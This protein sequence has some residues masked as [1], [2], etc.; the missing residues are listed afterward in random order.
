MRLSVSIA[1]LL[2]ASVSFPTIAT[3]QAQ[4]PIPQAVEQSTETPPPPPLGSQT[5]DALLALH[6]SLVEIESITGNEKA[7]GQ[8]LASY[9]EAQKWTVELQEAAKNRYNVLAYPGKERK[10][11]ILV[12]SH[13]DTV[14]GF[15]C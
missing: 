15:C 7:V 14:R 12:S 9:L 3:A 11:K 8:W 10:T 1:L 4:V 6:K 5:R 2:S 13:I